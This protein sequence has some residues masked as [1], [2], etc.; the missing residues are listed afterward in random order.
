MTRPS[1]G[2]TRRRQRLL[3][4][5]L[6]V[7]LQSAIGGCGEDPVPPPRPRGVP[8][9]AVWSGGWDGGVFV[10]CS[11]REPTERLACTIVDDRSGDVW[12]S[13]A[14]VCEADRPSVS[15]EG[16][17]AKWVYMAQYWDGQRLVLANGTA[18]VALADLSDDS[19]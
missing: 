5:L 6:V 11:R 16:V 17:N 15:C 19:Q 14:L 13:G 1:T 7:W 3:A 10:H 12:Y 9:H 18:L 4:P 2:A 8:S